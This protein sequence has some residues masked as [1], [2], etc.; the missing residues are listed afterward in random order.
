MKCRACLCCRRCG[1]CTPHRQFLFQKQAKYPNFPAQGWRPVSR[2]HGER[3]Q[4]GSLLSEAREDGRAACNPAVAHVAEG[5]EA[6]DGH[7]VHGHRRLIPCLDPM[8]RRGIAKEEGE[9]AGRHRHWTDPLRN[10]LDG[11]EN[12]RAGHVPQERIETREVATPTREESD[13]LC[14]PQESEA[15]GG[16]TVCRG[17]RHPL[18]LPA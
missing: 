9:E 2:V 12:R 1:T 7:G 8:R 11:R 10:T 3:L 4:V 6:Y 15:E 13:R 5:R 18:G 17:G 14:Q 16:K